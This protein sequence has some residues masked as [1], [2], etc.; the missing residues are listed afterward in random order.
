MVG[1]DDLRPV[2][3]EQVA[4]YLHAALAQRS[5]FFQEC[6]RIEHH[7]VANYVHTTGAENASRYQLQDKSL[8]LDDDRVAGVVSAGVARHHGERLGEYVDDLALALVAP[9]GSDNDRSF[10][11]IQFLLR[12]ILCGSFDCPKGRTHWFPAAG[13]NDLKLG[14]SAGAGVY[15]LAY[16]IGLWTGKPS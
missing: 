3:D 4:I 5:D 14:C 9:L 6:Q 12:G 11:S 8:S 15:A 1:K 7:S 16:R 10:A 13:K 2:R